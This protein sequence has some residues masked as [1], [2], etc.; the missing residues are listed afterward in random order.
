MNQRVERLYQLL[1]LKVGTTTQAY[2]DWLR[3]QEQFKHNKLRHEQLV[4][5]RQDY[6]EQLENLGQEGTQVGRIRNRIDF[7]NHLDMALVQLNNH[8]AQ[9]AK[10]RSKSELIFK[11]AK[12]SEEGV[13]KLLERANKTL[14]IKKQRLEQK[15]NDEYAQK[16]WYSSTMNDQ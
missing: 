1:Q 14:Q 3:S 12:A 5:Y 8:L 7:I 9:L 11:E 6:L 4:V 2:Q 16:Q 15:E 13:R 10:Q